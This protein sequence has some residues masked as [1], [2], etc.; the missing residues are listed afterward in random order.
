MDGLLRIQALPVET[1]PQETV[2][3]LDVCLE[4][5]QTVSASCQASFPDLT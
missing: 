1:L 5:V 3:G 2:L 4:R